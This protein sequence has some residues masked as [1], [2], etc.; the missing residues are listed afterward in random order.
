MVPRNYHPLNT[1]KIMYKLQKSKM[2]T[3][4]DSSAKT[5]QI[6]SDYYRRRQSLMDNPH[7]KF[8]F[9]REK[10]I[11]H[12]RECHLVKRIPD[13]QFEMLT[14]FDEEMA[15]CSA[16]YRRMLIRSAF[17]NQHRKIGLYVKFFDKIGCGNRKLKK[18]LFKTDTQLIDVGIDDLT[19]KVNEDT[20]FLQICNDVLD[21]YH[22]N[23]SVNDDFTRTF[24]SGYHLQNVY[25]NPKY[26]SCAISEIMTYSWNVHMQNS[27]GSAG[28]TY[29]EELKSKF[30]TVNNYKQVKESQYH[31]TFHFLDYNY[32]AIQFIAAEDIIFNIRGQ[33]DCDFIGRDEPYSLF[34]CRVKKSDVPAFKHAMKLLKDRAYSAKEYEYIEA[35]Q[36]L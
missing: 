28:V 17:V 24:T 4:N 16:C 12:D 1:R 3:E 29:F 14:E 2:N 18:L 13:E 27:K 9:S 31:A 8:A 6:F 22:N 26:F 21:L 25:K 5:S 36:L 33:L 23:Y 7:N 35:C 20:W 11:I 15:P 19:I 10:R 30:N 34:Q 32:Q